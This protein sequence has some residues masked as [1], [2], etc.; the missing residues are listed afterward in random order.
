MRS[1]LLHG[2]RL[3][4]PAQTRQ[5]QHL[6]YQVGSVGGID[7]PNPLQ[8]IQRFFQKSPGAT[9]LGGSVSWSRA[10]VLESPLPFRGMAAIHPSGVSN[11]RS[12]DTRPLLKHQRA[13]VPPALSS[14]E[15]HRFASP[16]LS[17]P[18]NV[19]FGD[20]PKFGK[21]GKID[22]SALSGI[23]NHEHNVAPY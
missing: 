11:E 6:N 20:D 8:V 4:V 5:C 1:C 22:D 2:Q 17:H 23:P 10:H 19:S 18:R 15:P 9:F 7:L 16:P 3:L 12:I 13:L 14:S 21:L